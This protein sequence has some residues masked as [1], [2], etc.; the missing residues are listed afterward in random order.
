VNTAAREVLGAVPSESRFDP[1]DSLVL[2]G[3]DTSMSMFLTRPADKPRRAFVVLRAI[4]GESIGYSQLG[5][6]HTLGYNRKET[7]SRLESG[8]PEFPLNVSHLDRLRRLTPHPDR[9]E[10][11]EELLNEFQA[12]LAADDPVEK[13]RLEA[14]RLLNEGIGQ[15]P[16]AARQAEEAA[17][18]SG[19]ILALAEARRV[20]EA[21]RVEQFPQADEARR[22]EEAQRTDLAGAGVPSCTPG[23][24]F[25]PSALRS[26]PSVQLSRPHSLPLH[27]SVIP[28]AV[29]EG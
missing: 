26:S 12:A 10:A 27:L 1:V 21:H 7:I 25:H 22:E 11:F 29:Y 14:Q 9:A 5:F 20:K 15:A 8:K 18:L 28:Q 23:P 17:R 2:F 4:R 16:G 19:Q 3:Y 24:L 6:A 13:T